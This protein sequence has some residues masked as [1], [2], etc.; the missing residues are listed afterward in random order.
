MGLGLAAVAGGL[1]GL[2]GLLMLAGFVS[3]AYEIHRER[4]AGQPVTRPAWEAR[5]A[6]RA[7][8]GRLAYLRGVV[9]G[10]RS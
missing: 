4:K 3:A 8:G 7:A 10:L 1:I 6:R 5:A 9:R 2:F